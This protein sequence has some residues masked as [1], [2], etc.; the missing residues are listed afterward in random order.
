MNKGVLV[1]I[2]VLLAIVVVGIVVFDRGSAPPESG[3]PTDAPPAEETAPS[4]TTNTS[5]TNATQSSM[6]L[7]SSAFGYNE[8]IPSK[9]TCDGANTIPPLSFEGVPEEARSLVLIMDD[10]DIPDRVKQAKGIEVFD[11][12]A[13]FNIPPDVDGV[14]EGEEPRGA[15][16]GANDAGGNGYTGPCP[17]DAEHRYIFKLYALDTELDLQAGASKQEVEQ[18]M[19][20]H[21]VDRAE[22]IGRYERQ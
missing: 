18:A 21:I 14:T 22:L 15:V 19:E 1:S 6:Q 10:P 16:L 2:G 4:D 8:T 3:I 11:H 5:N 20:G 9:Y 7:T 17:P 13:A 12:W